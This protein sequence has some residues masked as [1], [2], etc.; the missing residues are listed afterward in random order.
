MRH[1]QN[2]H[3]DPRRHESTQGSPMTKEPD[4]ALQDRIRQRAYEMSQAKPGGSETEDW[5]QA[6]R[7][8]LHEIASHGKSGATPGKG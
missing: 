4:A 3:D 5:L 1:K 6:E 7:E 8:T 2:H